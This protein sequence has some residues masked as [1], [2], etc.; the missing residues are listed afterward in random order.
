MNTKTI[1]RL[2]FRRARKTENGHLFYRW[3]DLTKKEQQKN[4]DLTSMVIDCCISHPNRTVTFEQ[5]NKIG[6][7]HLYHFLIDIYNDKNPGKRVEVT[8]NGMVYRYVL[9]RVNN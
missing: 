2:P 6:L 8:D 5:M 9:H 7:T 4:M 3:N 1:K